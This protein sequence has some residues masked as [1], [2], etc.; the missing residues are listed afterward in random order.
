MIFRAIKKACEWIG[1]QDSFP[2]LR[3]E[4]DTQLNAYYGER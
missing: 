1:K 3:N 2:D 4:I